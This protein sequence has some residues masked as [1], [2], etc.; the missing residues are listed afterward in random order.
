MRPHPDLCEWMY[1]HRQLSAVMAVCVCVCAHRHI[2]VILCK[3]GNYK[4]TPGS[5][6]LQSLSRFGSLVDY[7]WPV[8]VFSPTLMWWHL[9]LQR[10]LGL[11][12]AVAPAGAAL[13]SKQSG[14]SG[15]WTDI[16][17]KKKSSKSSDLW[18]W[19][20]QIDLLIN[21]L[22]CSCINCW[23]SLLYNEKSYFIS[24]WFFQVIRKVPQ[25]C[26]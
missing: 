1:V 7:L 4:R 6:F 24:S 11:L 16:K 22:S 25:I 19:N 13:C 10:L 8:G 2:P 5:L 26:T 23:G 15:L 17:I 12:I 18:L 14:Q 9:R 20:H 3:L 21:P